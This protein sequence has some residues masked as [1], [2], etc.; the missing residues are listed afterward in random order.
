MNKKK[1]IKPELDIKRAVRESFYRGIMFGIIIALLAFLLVLTIDNGHINKEDVKYYEMR[2]IITVPINDYG[3][4]D[5]N[6]LKILC[7]NNM[8]KEYHCLDY[9]YSTS[10]NSVKMLCELNC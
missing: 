2:G 4:F 6:A 1:Q 7:E 5:W 10:G 9:R 3:E 8:P